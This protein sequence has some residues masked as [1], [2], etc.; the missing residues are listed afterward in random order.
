MADG[1]GGS[2]GHLSSAA[3][4]A[5][6]SFGMKL[7]DPYDLLGAI[8]TRRW[9]SLR[10]SRTGSSVD[11]VVYVEPN[12]SDPQVLETTRSAESSQTVPAGGLTHNASFTTQTLTGKIQRLGDF[13]D[14]DAVRALFLSQRQTTKLWH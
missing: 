2:I 10:R 12:G 1:C 13:I 5:A 9:E 8:D 6:S 7:R 14:T 11:S 3:T 4:V